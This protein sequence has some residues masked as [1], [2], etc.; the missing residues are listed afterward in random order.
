MVAGWF[1]AIP[2]NYQCGSILEGLGVENVGIH[3]YFM[4]IENILRP[5]GIIDGLLV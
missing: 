3:T 2:K 5:F 4:T 1:I